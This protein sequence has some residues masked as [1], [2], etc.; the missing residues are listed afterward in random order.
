M[1]RVPRENRRIRG[2]IGLGDIKT[3]KRPAC[4]VWAD[5][6]TAGGADEA[7]LLQVD[8]G[9][10]T[11]IIPKSELAK[12]YVPQ[13]ENNKYTFGRE[14][15]IKQNY[16]GDKN[17]GMVGTYI[18]VEELLLRQIING[19]KDIFD[20]DPTRHQPLNIDKSWGA[21]Q[22]LLCKD[23]DGGEP[24]MSYVVPI[25][26]ENELDCELGFN[27]YYITAKQVKEAANYLKSLDDNTLLNMYDFKMMKE[28][29]I[30][31][32]YGKENENEAGVF[33]EYI[34]SY[35]IEIKK[36]F[37]LTAEEGYAIIFFIM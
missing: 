34:Y 23:V 37:E 28:N 22:Y 26:D 25:R 21:I 16:Q 14:K 29:D 12:S 2:L 31:P 17:M 19:N 27:V 8:R 30:Y 35:L 6:R 10:L 33:Y 11:R 32:L 18:A 15:V 9:R 20:I 13:R 4:G 5:T 24:P 1:Q 36:F 3:S 7:S